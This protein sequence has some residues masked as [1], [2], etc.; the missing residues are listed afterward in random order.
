MIALL[1]LTDRDLW[2]FAAVLLALLLVASE[3]GH[4]AGA[5]ARRRQAPANSASIAVGFITGGLLTL[6]AFVLGIALSMASM[7]LEARRDSVLNEA[8][9]IG[10]VWLRASL[11]GPPEGPEIRR[12]LRDYI[13]VRI[14][15]VRDVASEDELARNVARTSALQQA[16]WH[17]AELAAQRSPGPVTALLIASLNDMIDL[18]LTNRRNFAAHIPPVVRWLL[19]IVSALAVGSM[20]YH[21]GLIG[22]RHAVVSALLLVVWTASIVLVTDIDNSRGG[23]VRSSAAPLIWTQEG[24]GPDN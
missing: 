5:A 21:F 12:Q 13:P 2:L 23:L 16:I 1:D 17:Q 4:W 9:A 19:V 14:A 6:F 10:T 20:G 18:S 11:A 22:A 3:A 7:R 24:F 8:N 15:S